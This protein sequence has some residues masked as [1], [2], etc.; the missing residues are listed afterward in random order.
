MRFIGTSCLTQYRRATYPLRDWVA[1]VLGRF[2]LWISM[3]SED[4]VT[5]FRA[6][7]V[8]A[9]SCLRKLHSAC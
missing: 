7:R 6:A 1:P 3:G 5:E 8:A 2:S 9:R 4:D